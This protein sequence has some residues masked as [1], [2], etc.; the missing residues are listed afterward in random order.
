LQGYD[1]KAGAYFATVVTQ[2]R[3]CL[4][5]EIADGAEG[6]NEAG[7]YVQSC[8]LKITEHFPHVELNAFIV[9]HNHVHGIIIVEA[10][11]AVPL[12]SV[13]QRNYYEHVV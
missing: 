5:G 7:K 9:M 4:F 11:H 13:W 3:A 1:Y 8:W 6:L 12:H 10:R 2:E